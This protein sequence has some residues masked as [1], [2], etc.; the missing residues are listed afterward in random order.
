M[1]LLGSLGSLNVLLSADTAQFSSAMDK[2]AYNAEKSLNKIGIQ[3]KLSLAV[4]ATALIANTKNAL[5]FVQSM[6]TMA[7][8]LGIT[9]TQMSIL[10][11]AA[12]MS[13]IDV[14]SL[15][16]AMGLMYKAAFK[17][18]KLFEDIGI[19][20]KDSSGKFR[21]GYAIF[22]DTIETLKKM[23][24]GAGKAAAA[25]QFF[26]RTGRDIVPLFTSGTESIKD[27][28]KAARSL[29]VVLEQESVKNA[30]RWDKFIKQA[31]EGM[32]GFGIA[33]IDVISWMT[34]VEN[35]L[36]FYKEL[37]GNI[38]DASK[39]SEKAAEVDKKRA[40]ALADQTLAYEQ[41][42]AAAEKKKKLD[43][44]GTKLTES[45]R[46]AQEIH[47]EEL[48]K[49][50]ELLDAGTISS[51]TY[52][53]AI[54][55]SATTLTESTQKTNKMKDAAKD[56][57]MTFSSA[58][59]D[60][61]INGEKLSDVLVSLLKD[62]ERI[63]LRTAITGPLANALSAG[64]SSFFGPSPTPSPTTT[65]GGLTPYMAATMSAKGNIFSGNRL[66]PFANGGL[67]DRPSIF[68]MANGGVGLAGEKGTEAILPLFRTGSG[69]LGVKSGSGGG[70][71]INVYAPAG[72][73][74]KQ[75]S[76]RVGD[77]DQIN[78]MID[79]AVAGSVNSPGSKTYKA[80]RGSF[81]LKQALNA[82]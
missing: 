6:D 66:I 2:A 30:A 52:E 13:N 81:G 26:G 76:Q 68:P 67:I 44:E 46:T 57:G 14:S 51:E 74:V 35:M 82:R 19:K 18:P 3:A 61:I 28:E 21:D 45:L 39:A 48:I 8:H 56:L 62:I 20:V 70:V 16:T 53:R 37:S 73:S 25:M 49:Y 78:I 40:Q 7:K 4:L 80:L 64:I 17:T 55:K 72:S 15:E 77:K 79:E 50:N 42:A 69:D 29:G 58:F 10:S 23:P 41:L 9:A 22:M 34:K 38:N 71:E 47:N 12:K 75:N 31:M 36:P 5:D 33:T 24:D 63:I 11:Y 32:K 54:K 27:F 60:A 1:G 59:E 43:E 65:S